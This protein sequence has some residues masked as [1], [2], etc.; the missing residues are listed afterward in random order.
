[1]HIVVQVVPGSSRESIA[2]VGTNAYG[3]TIYKI[4]TMAK[5]VDNAAN[6]A[7]VGILA[8]HFDVPKRLVHLKGGG[9]SREKLF[10]IDG[11]DAL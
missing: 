11:I 7:L 6:D 10:V 3:H 5:P 8:R 1:M 2:I 4:K 9:S